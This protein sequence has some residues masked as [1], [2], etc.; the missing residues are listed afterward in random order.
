MAWVKDYYGILGCSPSADPVVV[1]AAWRALLAKYHPDVDHSDE[2][3]RKLAL[4]NEAWDVLGNAGSRA[5]YDAE[6]RAPGA[7]GHRGERPPAPPP[8]RLA[9]GAGYRQTIRVGRRRRRASGPLAMLAAAVLG[10][11]AT[12]AALTAFYS[13]AG[14]RDLADTAWFARPAAADAATLNIDVRRLATLR[15][16]LESRRNA[17]SAGSCVLR[18]S[19]DETADAREVCPSLGLV[20]ECAGGRGVCRARP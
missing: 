7:F 2:A 20:A 9:S 4:V 10:T 18:A 8:P 15:A 6:L 17:A 16:D 14:V 5:R 13:P 1:R 19:E 3:A 11:F 12:A